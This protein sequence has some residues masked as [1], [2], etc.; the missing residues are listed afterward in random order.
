MTR[1][2]RFAGQD[3]IQRLQSRLAKDVLR[4][5]PRLASLKARKRDM[6]ATSADRTEPGRH[7]LRWIRREIEREEARRAAACARTTR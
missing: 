4:G 7:A 1:T 2:V 3:A 5:I 6:L